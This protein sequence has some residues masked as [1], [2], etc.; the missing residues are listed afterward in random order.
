M[1]IALNLLI[2]LA[3]WGIFV[4]FGEMEVQEYPLNGDWVPVRQELGGQELPASIFANQKMVLADSNYTVMA[5]SIDKGV[6]HYQKGRMDIY[7]MQGVN[8]GKHFTAIYRQDG[9]ELWICYNLGG[10]SYPESFNTRGHRFFFLSI[11]RK[12]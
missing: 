8:K 9:D 7:G 2:L 6:V 1:K 11:F 10:E 3:L 4:S 12:Q 5:E